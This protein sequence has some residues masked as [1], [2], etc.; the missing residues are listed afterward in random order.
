MKRLRAILDNLRELL[1]WLRARKLGWLAP[2][3]FVLVGMGGLLALA[4]AVP[5]ISPFVYLLF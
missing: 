3:V 4:A 2:L 1:A 5:A